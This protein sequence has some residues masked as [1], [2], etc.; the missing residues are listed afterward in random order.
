[1]KKVL[2][3]ILAAVLVLA[4]LSFALAEEGKEADFLDLMENTGGNLRRIT[5]AVPTAPGVAIVPAPLLPSDTGS[6][7]LSDG[8][9]QWKAE[10]VIPDSTG[11]LA[12]VFYDA[13]AQA[14][15]A[16]SW[17]FI[18]RGTEV[19]PADCCVLGDD[20]AERD[21]LGAEEI[22]R[23]GKPFLL[24]S[25]SGDAPAGS[26]LLTE[27][28]E[29][30]GIVTA[31][32]AEG[33][34]RVLVMKTEQIA[35]EM[36]RAATLL[37]NLPSWQEVPEGLNVTLNR[38]LVT[39]EW[40]DMALP[41]KKED[42]SVYMVVV[43]AGNTYLSFY[44]AETDER[45]LTLML[46]PGRFYMVGPVAS[47]GNPARLPERYAL[48]SVPMAEKLTEYHFRPVITAIAEGP[49]GGLKGAE[50]P[51]PVDEVT[52]ELLRSGRAYFYAHSTYEV[53]RIIEGKTLLVTLTDPN[54]VNY[55]HESSWIYMPEFSDEDIWFLNLTDIG[56][57]ISFDRGGYPKGTYQM[58]YYVDGELADAFEFELK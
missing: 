6:L 7:F 52:E 58:A 57:T 26:L 14:P 40:K 27:D 36:N 22:L 19:S 15:S 13:S 10:A 48:V 8:G 37:G 54:G 51:V 24:L 31:Q 2:L 5:S 17:T 23:N 50:R 41:E 56:M 29:L 39:I 21:V 18:Y 16:G 53:D 3:P 32:W 25:L 38:N 42:E 9:T 1:M 28:G 43:D 44:P 49:E 34:H 55:R 47:A 11:S 33:F 30:A 35:M 20:G 46:T 12:V 4:S 45:T